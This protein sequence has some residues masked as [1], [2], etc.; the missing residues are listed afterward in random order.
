M[1]ELEKKFDEVSKVLKSVQSHMCMYL[2]QI[3]NCMYMY[4]VKTAAEML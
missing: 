1:K 4:V 3:G 2:W